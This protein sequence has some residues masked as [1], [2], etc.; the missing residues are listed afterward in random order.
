MV[1]SF[2]VAVDMLSR[3]RE[4]VGKTIDDRRR[5]PTDVEAKEMNQNGLMIWEDYAYILHMMAG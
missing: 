3:W 1:D 5:M 4:Q 2:V